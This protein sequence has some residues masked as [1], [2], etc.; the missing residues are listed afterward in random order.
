MC[1]RDSLFAVRSP[2]KGHL[3]FDGLDSRNW[4]LERLRQ[5]IILLRRDEFFA[6]TVLDNLRMGHNE[7]TINEIKE[8]LAQV[9]ILEELLARPNG[10]NL[11]LDLGG[12][13]L[14]ASQKTRLLFARALVHQPRLL[15]ID[16]LLDPLDEATFTLLTEL[17][18]SPDKPWTV[19]VATRR[20]QARLLCEQTINLSTNSTLSTTTPNE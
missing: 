20:K 10:L 12:S 19:V 16:E 8:A 1:I 6:G 7:I 2:S 11:R 4:Q 13:P 18:F 14:S 15:L 9:G 3:T 5:S 17:I